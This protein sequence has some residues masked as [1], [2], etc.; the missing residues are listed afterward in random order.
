MVQTELFDVGERVHLSRIE[1][2]IAIAEKYGHDIQTAVGCCEPGY[3]DKPVAM[4]NW[5][6]D[7]HY[8]DGN[9]VVNNDVM[10][11]LSELFEKLGY[12][13]EWEDE[14]STCEDCGK[15]F[16][17]Q[18]DSYSWKPSYAAIGDCSLACHN[19]IRNAPSDYVEGLNGN[20]DVCDT[21]GIDL[22]QF[23]YEL[24]Q[25]GYESGWYGIEDKPVKIAKELERKGIRDYIFVLDGNEQFRSCFSVW[26]KKK[27]EDD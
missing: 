8:V 13:V 17:T 18:P 3:D 19:C 7:S 23:G 12:S 5:N 20:P 10:P 1:L 26:V 14:W 24:F 6:D 27:E 25:D 4:S 11:R 9:R 15:V 22:E 2:L 21:I 16:R